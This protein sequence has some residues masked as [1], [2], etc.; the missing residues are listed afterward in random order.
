MYIR[1]SLEAFL[2]KRLTVATI[3]MIIQM[4]KPFGWY[5][6]VFIHPT[7][8]FATELVTDNKFLSRNIRAFMISKEN[9]DTFRGVV[10]YSTK[11]DKVIILEI[12]LHITVISHECHG[13]SNQRQLE[14]FFILRYVSFLIW[15][16]KAI[17]EWNGMSSES[18]CV[19]IRPTVEFFVW[20]SS[21]SP[22]SH[23][24]SNVKGIWLRFNRFSRRNHLFWPYFISRKLT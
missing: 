15:V 10:P 12:G 23:E 18:Q 7:T 2:L 11:L 21:S 22:R 19:Y 8:F 1:P 20:M 17:Y 24:K 14:C 4:W 6:R 16:K 13:V 9:A 5:L 3:P